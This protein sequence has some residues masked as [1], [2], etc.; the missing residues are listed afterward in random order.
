M[1]KSATVNTVLGPVSTADL[2]A[3][4]THEHLLASPMG[5]E[6]DST[7]LFDREGQLL[8]IIGD[9]KELRGA[10]IA[11]IID[12][13]PIELGRNVE[14]M[15]D[16]ARASGINIICA[17]GLYHEQGT[18][19]GYPP[20]FKMKSTDDLAQIY[21]KEITDGVGPDRVR[22]GV[23]KCATGPGLITDH[24]RKALQAA[25]RAHKATGVPITTHTTDGTMGPEQL[26]IF[27]EE[28]VDLHYVTVGHCSD[29]A[30]LHYLRRIL[31]R[32][33]FVGFDRVGLEGHV[34]DE[35]KVGVVAALVAMGFID[36]IVLSHDH[37]GC[38]HGMRISMMND[39]EAARKRSYTYLL[40]E[41]LPK[42]KATGITDDALNTMLVDNPRR[43]FEGP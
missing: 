9:M 26:D 37:V 1:A 6:Y 8:K 38:M 39:P 35:A 40:R 33:A 3:T 11:T 18:F 24:E 25:A 36:Q 27:E 16:V 14:F 30:D 12:P 41:F 32:G 5:V 17:T 21:I 7:L 13:I 10:G 42:L 28:G 23:I 4:L 2:G 34:S 43:F 22:P 19:S 31:T 29:S 15:V 20:Y